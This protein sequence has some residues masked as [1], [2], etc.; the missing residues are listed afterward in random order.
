MAAVTI[1]GK[2]RGIVDLYGPA[3]E[4]QARTTYGNLN[5]GAHTI[6]IQVLGRKRPESKGSFVDVDAI[7]VP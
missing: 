5:L 3:V 4:W 1:D 6:Q 2:P 7:V